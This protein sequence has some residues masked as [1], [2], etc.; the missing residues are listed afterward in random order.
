MAASKILLVLGAGKNI[1]QSLGRG[2]KAAGYKVALVSRSAADGQT[3]AEGFLTLRADLSNHASVPPL[4]E[5]VKKKL[6]GPPTVVVYNAGAVVSP[7]DAA[8]PFTVPLDG[9]ES[10]TAVTHT[11]AYVAAR[12]AVAGWESLPKEVP[13]AF[14]YTGNICAAVVLPKTF[15]VSFGSG[16]SAASYWIGLASEVYKEKGYKFYFADE[17]VETGE[18]VYSKISGPAAG[19][20]YLKL[21]EEETDIPWYATFVAGKGFVD[22]PESRRR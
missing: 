1:G 5:A 14:I 2:F 7:V 4:F 18:P 3:T 21:A 10:V 9:L 8:N 19:E 11:S 12:E 17:R 13:K 16:K 20:F 15:T 22:F 6:G